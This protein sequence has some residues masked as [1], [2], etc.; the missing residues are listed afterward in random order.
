[1]SIRRVLVEALEVLQS[2]G[3]AV[4]GTGGNSGVSLTADDCARLVDSLSAYRPQRSDYL[5]N[6]AAIGADR[7]L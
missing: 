5:D 2:I 6:H 1:M 4:N 7:G 3:K